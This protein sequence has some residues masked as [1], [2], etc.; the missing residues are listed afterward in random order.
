[1][2]ITIKWLKILYVAVFDSCQPHQEIS[3]LLWNKKLLYGI[4]NNLLSEPNLSH[5]NAVFTLTSYFR[6]IYFNITATPTTRYFQV[7]SLRE[8]FRLNWC[9]WPSSRLVRATCPTSLFSVLVALIMFDGEKK[10][11]QLLAISNFFHLSVLS[12]MIIFP[13][14]S[15]FYRKYCVI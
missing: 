1:M 5:F 8:N 2:K 13:Y 3:H 10:N 14:L 9:I 11:L 15:T 6:N 7:V 4:K 12:V